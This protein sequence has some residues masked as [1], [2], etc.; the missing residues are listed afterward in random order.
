MT[1]KHQLKSK[2]TWPVCL[3]EWNWNNGAG[4][5]PTAKNA[6]FVGL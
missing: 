5:M 2:L 4:A 1:T 3:R 6:V